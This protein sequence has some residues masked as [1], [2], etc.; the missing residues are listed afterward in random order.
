MHTVN[1]ELEDFKLTYSDCVSVN[2]KNQ[3]RY[4]HTVI[5]KLPTLTYKFGEENRWPATDYKISDRI[6]EAFDWGA[7][8]WNIETKYTD[9]GFEKKKNNQMLYEEDLKKEIVTAIIRVN[10]KWQERFNAD[11]EIAFRDKLLDFIKSKG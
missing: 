1:S 2:S 7:S 3:K 8:Y 5:D 6:S 11:F 4:Q 10:N 9:K